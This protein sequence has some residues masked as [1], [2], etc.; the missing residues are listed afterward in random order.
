M[1]DNTNELEAMKVDELQAM[2]KER[3]LTGYS[4]MRKDELVEALG[5]ATPAEADGGA[6]SESGKVE[7]S[8]GR[9]AHRM[10]GN[11]DPVELLRKDHETVKGLFSEFESASSVSDQGR[12][13]RESLLELDVHAAIE[14]EIYYP[15]AEQALGEAGEDTMHEAEEEHHVVHV[16]TEE[17][18][19][20]GADDP[21]F[22]A[23]F[24]VL[25]EMVR[26]HIEEEEQ[27]MLPKAS[28]ALGADRSREL[29]AEMAQ[30]KE[31]LTTEMRASMR[32]G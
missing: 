5:E 11:V 1:A 30:R 6:E 23:K 15:A 28:K 18:R 9:S 31:E 12:L 26:H 2:A 13:V 24:T 19:G 27:E 22:K 29:G 20:L 17:I 25:M 4:S 32:A 14:E 16:L 21:Q 8:R 10:T 3:G 7:G